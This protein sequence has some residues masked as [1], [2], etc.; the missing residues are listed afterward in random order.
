MSRLKVGILGLGAWGECHLEACG[1]LAEVEVAAVCDIREER[2]HALAD[3]FGVPHRYT[4]AEQLLDR[5]DLDL[6]S[7]VLAEQDHLQPTLHALRTGKHVLVEKPV[8]TRPEEAVQMLAAANAFGKIAAPGHLLRFEPKYA[9]VRQSIVSGT[10]GKPLSMYFRRSRP[11]SLF[12]TYKRTHIAFVTAVHDIDLAI[13]YAGGRV[14]NVRAFARNVRDDRVPE[15]LWA[16]LEFDHGAIGIVQSNWMTHDAA[17][18]DMND[19]L[20]VVCEHGTALFDNHTS[21]LQLWSAEGRRSADNTVHSVIDRAASGALR[22]Q[23]AYLS[24]CIRE[25]RQPERLSFADAVHG[26]QVAEAIVKSAET[27]RDVRIEPIEV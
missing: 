16:C 12:Q 21:G 6:V 11:R 13:W 26:V 17:G 8:S 1:S 10:L 5:D 18:I 3:R 25:G 19:A 23:Y 2:V 9:A 7:I 20:E 22:E 27:G 14:T 4:T 24:R 15:V